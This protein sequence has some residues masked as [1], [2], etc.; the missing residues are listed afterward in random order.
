ME[1]TAPAIER[2][3]RL[4]AAGST[5]LEIPGSNIPVILA[6][7]GYEAKL[8]PQAVH[9]EYAE[10]PHKLESHRKFYSSASFVEYF[11]RFATRDSII[12]ANPETFTLRAVLDYHI[13]EV[14]GDHTPQWERHVATLEMKQSAQIKAWIGKDGVLMSQS[15]FAEF[16]QEN[17]ADLQHPSVSEMLTIARDLRAYVGMTAVSN[18]N[19]QTGEV[20]LTF[21]NEVS[22][23]AGVRT[24]KVEIP[25][26]FEL[27]V[28]LFANDKPSPVI[29]QFRFRAG[30]EMKLMYKLYQVNRMLEQRFEAL[31][32]EIQGAVKTAELPILIGA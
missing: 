15:D 16:L 14:E 25:D 26:R 1:L 31:V 12:L 30:Q 2:L 7:H 17:A 10:Q 3:E 4:I 29:A 32:A 19:Q 22:A 5:V 27:S 21:K 23:T 28:P 8:L 9:N 18:F 11:N 24:A 20:E 6:P 13:A